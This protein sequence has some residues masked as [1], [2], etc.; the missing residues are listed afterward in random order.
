MNTFWL[1]DNSVYFIEVCWSYRIDIWLFLDIVSIFLRRIKTQ[2]FSEL[3]KF[4]QF[5]LHKHLWSEL[6]LYKQISL[7]NMKQ[8]CIIECV[9]LF[10]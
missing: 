9:C 8:V 2:E 1:A 3:N 5:D 6:Y 7:F 4:Y 10:A